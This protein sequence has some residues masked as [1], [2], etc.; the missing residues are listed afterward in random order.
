[1]GVSTSKTKT[2]SDAQS[3][4]TTTPN[5]PTYASAP[6]QDYYRQVGGIGANIAQNPYAYATPGN[7][8]QGLAVAGA[9]NLGQWQGGLDQST[10]MATDAAGA[11]NPQVQAQSL[12]TNLDAYQ[13]PASA[14]LVDTTLADFDQNAGRVRAQQTAQAARNGA[15]GGSRYAIQQGTTEGEIARARAATDAQLRSNAYAQAVAM[16]QSDANN[17]QQASSQNAGLAS[18]GLDR[19]LNAAGLVGNNANARGSNQIADIQAQLLAGNNQYSVDSAYNQTPITNMQ[20]LS[21]LINPQ[22]VNTISGQTI[23]SK[24]SGTSVTK[25]QGSLFDKVL[26]AAQLA[27]MA[28]DRRLKTN[29]ERVGELPDGL[30]LYAYDYVWGGP[31][32]VGVMA[33]EVAALRPDALGPII[34]GFATV[35]YGAL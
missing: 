8:T 15:F 24:E 17:R 31:R 29:V 7:T 30:S 20:A 23:D 2:T 34:F 25:Q 14:A 33:D 28:S 9:N 13:N 27:A 18:Q 11:A 12:L 22:L 19:R 26:A 21:G 16:S 1:M 5:V 6:I 3:N 10:Q 32:Q 4:A 35:N